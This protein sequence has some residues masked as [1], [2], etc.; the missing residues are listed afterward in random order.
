[1]KDR[2]LPILC[3]LSDAELQE[4]R[5]GVLQDASRAVLETRELENGFSFS[6]P[7]TYLKQLVEIT[8]FER[9][10]CAFLTFHLTAEPD[11]GPIRLEV[12]GP[13]PSKQFIATLFV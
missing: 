6:F 7:S 10:C 3:T 5:K 12:T 2:E 11:H 4:R 13:A 8:E 1:M 9:Q